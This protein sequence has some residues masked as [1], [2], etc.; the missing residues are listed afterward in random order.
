MTPSKK[1][2]KN[3]K[4]LSLNPHKSLKKHTQKTLKKPSKNHKKFSKNTDN[5]VN[6]I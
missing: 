3:C 6:T 5:P 2:L 4:I 1:P